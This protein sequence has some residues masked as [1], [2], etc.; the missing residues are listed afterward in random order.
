MPD[1]LA[2][3]LA[4]YRESLMENVAETDDELIEKFL[5]EGELTTEEI[6]QGLRSGVAK[7]LLTP[8]C[9]CSALLNKGTAA[10]L[11][12][13]NMFLPSPAERPAKVGKVPGSQETAERKPLPEAAF[14]RPGLQD[15]GRSVCRT[16]DHFQGLVR[17]P[18]GGHL[19]QRQQVPVLSGS[20]SFTSSRARSRNRWIPPAPA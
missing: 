13:I 20:V 4:L 17:H 7:A 12:S 14:L 18:Q 15:H 10:L 16:A 19:L 8:V 6:L 3:D 9:V 2:D 11:D 1:D 5:E